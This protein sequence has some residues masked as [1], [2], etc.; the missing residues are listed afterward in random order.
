MVSI[1]IRSGVFWV[2][3]IEQAAGFGDF[4]DRF[5]PRMAKL[6]PKTLYLIRHGE[7][8][9]NRQRIIQ[10]SGLDAPLN[11]LG[12]LQALDFY[13]AYHHIP[14]ELVLTSALIRT[15][16][17]VA[18]FIEAGIP[19]LILP[20]LNEISWGVRDGTRIDPEELGYYHSMIQDWKSGLLDRSFEKGESPNQVAKRLTVA[21]E[22]LQSRQESTILL[23]MHGRAM[24]IFLCLLL[25]L[26]LTEME[27]F[28]HSNLC[29]YVL[30]FDGKDWSVRLRNDAHHLRHWS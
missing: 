21:I 3:N 24:R 7:T 16:Q 17:S 4:P 9:P 26:P 20:E 25:H 22:V 14:F 23:C 13:K 12:H 15:H 29:L 2:A 1:D 11:S 27:T 28:A 10:G 30:E 6:L 19:Q 8:D 18:P 5:A